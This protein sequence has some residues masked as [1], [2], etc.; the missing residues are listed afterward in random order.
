[1]LISTLATAQ[2]AE[3]EAIQKTITEV[4]AGTDAR[5]WTQVENA[6]A[7]QVLL[8]YN[9]LAGGE[10]VQLTPQEIT[11]NWKKVLPGFDR[12]QHSIFDF[13]ISIQDQEAKVLHKGKADHFLGSG[14]DNSWT[15][16]GNYELHLI[17][18]DQV[19]KIDHMKFNLEEIQGNNDLPRLAQEAVQSAQAFQAGLNII[20][21]QSQGTS[22]QQ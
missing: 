4:F 15:V 10:A 16:I 6:F 7:E 8:D 2:N 18:E 20:S 22:R 12:T 13:E 3:M 11:D 21:F 5:N 14:V 1:M 19:W 17:Q 9:S